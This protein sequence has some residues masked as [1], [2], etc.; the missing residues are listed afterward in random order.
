MRAASRVI[1]AD[2]E[3][4]AAG[5]F[6]RPAAIPREKGVRSCNIA[7]SRRL[8]GSECYIARLDRKLPKLPKLPYCYSCS[9]KTILLA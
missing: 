1:T 8:K 9:K 6:G 2:E 7:P 5:F 3:P 4:G